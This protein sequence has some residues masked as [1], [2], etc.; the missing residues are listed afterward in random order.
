MGFAG[1]V[2]ALGAE[3]LTFKPCMP[4]EIES[5]SFQVIWKGQRAAIDVTKN[6][7]S[8]KNMSDKELPFIVCGNSSKVDKGAEASLSY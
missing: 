3:T 2:N 8:V 6:K 5:I 1:M 7:V 4:D